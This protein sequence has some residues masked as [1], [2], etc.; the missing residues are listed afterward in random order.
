MPDLVHGIDYVEITSGVR[1]ITPARSSI[2]G[3]V[4]TAP[5][6]SD[7][8]DYAFPVDTPVLIT[9]ALQARQLIY[10]DVAG[11]GDDGGTLLDAIEG[12]FAQCNAAVVMTRVAAGVDDAA[13]ATAAAGSA[14][15]KTGIWALLDSEG[16]TGV[17][18]R[19]LAAPGI[20]QFATGPTVTDVPAALL[21]VAKRLLG[22]AIIES[23][24][25]TAAD[26]A[27]AEALVT[28]D[29]SRAYFVDPFVTAGGITKPPSGYIAG[30]IALSDQERG[31]WW[32]PSNRP[33]TGITGTSRMVD[34]AIGDASCEADILNGNHIATIIRHNGFRL[35]GGRSL[36]KD[37]ARW[38]FISTRR[39]ADQ[40]QL[41][42][43][44]SHMWAV[45][46][47]ITRNYV[48][49]VK[50][51]IESYLRNLTAQGAILGGSVW[52]DED[53]NTPE[54]IANGEVYWDFDFTPVSPAEKLTFRGH[55][56][57]DYISEVV[58]A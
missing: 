33:L 35:W 56:T 32:N 17:V 53:L 52:L 23:G 26:A 3:I 43:K 58:P 2:I 24:N 41:A 18:P 11:T 12:I 38:K 30:L 13:T 15:G 46:R 9:T 42:I 54:A 40:I 31:W 44:T 7:T 25:T 16:A 20:S 8:G 36:E 39:I 51:G 22:I 57:N 6:A 4:G 10:N 55:L 37:D 27:T 29:R 50:A 19:I 28:G 34:F 49:E 5:E 14:S 48:Q 21:G 45:D 47:N 1:P